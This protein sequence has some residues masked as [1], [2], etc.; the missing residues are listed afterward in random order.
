LDSAVGQLGEEA[1]CA[2]VTAQLKK[3]ALPSQVKPE[4]VA[5]L[6]EKPGVYVFEGASGEPLY[7]GKSINIKARVMS[8]FSD[9]K[10]SDREFRIAQN[11]THISTLVTEGELGALLKESQL[12]KALQPLHNRRL[13]N[14]VDMWVAYREFDQ[15][16]YYRL[17]L[18]RTQSLDPEEFANVMRIYRS[19]KQAEEHLIMAAAGHGLCRKLLGIEKGPGSCFASQLGKCEGACRQSEPNLEYNLRFM[20]AFANAEGSEWPFAGAIGI[21]E[22]AVTYVFD[23]WC[24]RAEISE[25]EEGALKA[26][27]HKPELDLDV[28]HILRSY[29]RSAT[30]VRR[31]RELPEHWV[32]AASSY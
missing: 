20:E 28:Y 26:K 13:R 29:L 6:P 18:D 32:E 11:L 3:Q 24:L 31:V 4:L 19:R 27:M 23:K 22:G 2:A 15:D 1:V 16:G 25:S 14:R 7:V 17:R 30:N 12:I 8:H 21:N 9:M 5:N 10:R